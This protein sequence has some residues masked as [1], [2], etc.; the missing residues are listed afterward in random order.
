MVSRSRS[1]T[2]QPPRPRPLLITDNPYLLDD[3]LR[4]AA[5]VG[6]DVEV[7]PDA[8]AARERYRQAPFVLVG[9]EV[10][11]E[12]ARAL[13]S[14]PGI[15]LVGRHGDGEPR[16]DLAGLLAAEHVAVLPTAEPWLAGC[17]RQGA[18]SR[19]APARMFAVLGGRGGAGASVLAAGIAVS[20][21]RTGRRAL[22]IDADPLGGGL[23]LILGWE[24]ADGLRWPAF[25]HTDGPISPP[26]LV[27]SLPRRGELAVLSCD[28]DESTGLPAP[29]MAAAIDAG[30]RGSDVVVAD[31]PRH[32]D[33]A[34]VTALA[35][36]D[37]A[38]LVVPAE[39]R[40]CA[41]AARVA[42]V[43]AVHTRAL[44]V[45]VRGPAPGRLRSRD[46]AR[47]LG[48]PLAGT[49]RAEAGLARALERG[50]PPAG[51]GHGPLAELCRRL[52]DHAETPGFDSAGDSAA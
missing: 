30:R 47:T 50:E 21:A 39:L 32:L 51:T 8:V 31:L 20:A 16:W 22:L 19:S 6:A 42:A 44:S 2:A 25:A 41:A 23:D 46:I 52:L 43:A 9:E 11:P 48:L 18:A 38:F 26:A 45:V 28:R 10:A 3:V 35:A 12:C 49:V 33:D 34:A 13:P 37:R 7:A 40:A 15:V 5:S 14:R 17:F 1:R 24:G 29:A 36:A 27:E 4:I